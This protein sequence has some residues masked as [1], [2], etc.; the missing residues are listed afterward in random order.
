ML[1][2]GTGG[3]DL[4]AGRAEAAAGILEVLTVD[5]HAHTAIDLLELDGAH[6]AHLLTGAHAAAAEDAALHL[7]M[8][9]LLSLSRV[10]ILWGRIRFSEVSTI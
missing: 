2:D 5:D 8:M 9:G 4:H 3:A 7:V 1:P 6:A 10:V